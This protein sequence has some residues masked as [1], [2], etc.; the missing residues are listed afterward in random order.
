MISSNSCKGL[1]LLEVMISLAILM[2]GAVIG[3]GVIATTSA[4]G[5]ITKDQALAYKGCQDIMEAL[6]SMD[7]TTLIAQKTWQDAN[8]GSSSFA[9]KSLKNSDASSPLGTYTLTDVSARADASAPAN[10][11]LEITVTFNWK[12]VRVLL[13][14]RRY[15]P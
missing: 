9:M 12:N 7:K 13:C 2:V 8:G 15:L 5:E 10:S 3:L 6:M 4:R 11:L 14:N 1:T